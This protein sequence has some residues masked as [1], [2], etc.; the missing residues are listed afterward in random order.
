MK[1]MDD[2][3]GHQPFNPIELQ[4]QDVMLQIQ[5]QLEEARRNL[6]KKQMDE[7]PQ[8]SDRQLLEAI[9]KMLLHRE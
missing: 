7:I 9:Y 6:I 8:M 1:N 2:F 5:M 4:R 3:I